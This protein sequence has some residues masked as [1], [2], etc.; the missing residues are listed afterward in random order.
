[1]RT[2]PAAAETQG[3]AGK[4]TSDLA[5]DLIRTLEWQFDDPDAAWDEV[6]PQVERWLTL[7]AQRSARAQPPPADAGSGGTMPTQSGT[8]SGARRPFTGFERERAT[9]ERHKAEWL[10]TAEGKFMVIVGDDF[11]GPLETDE[12]AE[13]AGYARF[14]LG[15]LYIKQVLSKDPPPALITRDVVPC[16]T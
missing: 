11:V 1:V 8:P 2:E 7:R 5:E 15:P 9:Y 6:R 14:G 3:N 12:E 10:K 13:R 16:R 4:T